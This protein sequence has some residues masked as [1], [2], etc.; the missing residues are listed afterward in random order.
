M[1]NK[2]TTLLLLLFLSC[3][4]SCKQ[5]IS[6]PNTDFEKVFGTWNYVRAFG[7][8]AGQEIII[9]K[10]T[11]YKQTVRFERDGISYW[12]YDG[13]LRSKRKFK[14]KIERSN[15]SGKISNKILIKGYIAQ[16]IFFSFTKDTLLLSEEMDDG[17][18]STYI[19]K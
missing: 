9:E 19:R 1:K 4:V 10:Y 7:G 16:T 18:I 17:Y 6:V 12:Y 2:S 8:E 3:L 11:G 14:F 15:M 5:D 13:Y